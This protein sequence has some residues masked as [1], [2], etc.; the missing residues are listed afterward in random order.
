MDEKNND[1]K[2]LQAEQEAAQKSFE[3]RRAIISY[4]ISL[5]SLAASVAALIVALR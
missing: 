5:F 1:M 4:G 2:T 3:Q